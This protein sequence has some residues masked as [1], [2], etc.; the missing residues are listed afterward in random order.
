MRNYQMFQKGSN[1]FRL[2]QRQ[3]EC[4]GNY[5]QT[6]NHNSFLRQRERNPEAGQGEEINVS[7]IHSLLFKIDLSN[8]RNTPLNFREVYVC[9]CGGGVI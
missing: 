5:K 7:D 1:R 3:T 8:I 6:E 4:Y 2:Y 9:V